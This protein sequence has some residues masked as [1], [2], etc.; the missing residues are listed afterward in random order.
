MKE[1]KNNVKRFFNTK[2]AHRIFSIYLPLFKGRLKR[3][4]VVSAGKAGEM[5]VRQ[6]QREQSLIYK[7]IVFVDDS[8]GHQGMKINGIPVLG[9]VESIPHWVKRKKIDEIIIAAT[10]ATA[11]QMRCIIQYCEESGVIFKT[12][13]GTK[14]I[15]NNQV[16]VENIRDLKIEDLLEV[17]HVISDISKMSDYFKEK[18]VLVTGAA[19]SIGSE[20]CRQLAK[21]SPKKLIMLDRAENHLVDLE[22]EVRRI[23]PVSDN[24]I[25]V[26]ADITQF[27]RLGAIF[28]EYRLDIVFHAAAYKHVQA[29]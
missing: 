2:F 23:A 19:G 18:V 12:L 15:G 26:I 4:L 29:M 10:S 11:A 22:Y 3:A 9:A 25:C 20:I 28:N 8:S 13:P 14:E 17:P 21:L 16:S 7:P 5:I 6:M 24:I 1:N 27:S